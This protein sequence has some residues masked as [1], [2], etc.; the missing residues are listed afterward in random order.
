M[1]RV[2]RRPGWLASLTG[3]DSADIPYCI[4]LIQYDV[5]QLYIITISTTLSYLS[6]VLPRGVEHI[7]LKQVGSIRH[8]V[9][10]T[11]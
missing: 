4:A 9:R 5:D 6:H 7:H 1:I 3:A 11:A 8:R 10:V 2:R